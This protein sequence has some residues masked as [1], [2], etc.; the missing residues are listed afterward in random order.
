MALEFHH[1]NT[2][3]KEFAISK[4]KLYKFIDMIK[5]EL[6]KCDVLCS[7]CHKEVHHELAKEKWN[8]R[9]EV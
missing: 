6:D 4:F 3:E 5:N 7:N 2:T 1:R 8:R 9:Q